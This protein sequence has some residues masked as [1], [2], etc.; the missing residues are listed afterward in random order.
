MPSWS[1]GAACTSASA[2]SKS[3][4][5]RVSASDHSANCSA[6]ELVG[7]AGAD[8]QR[9]AHALEVLGHV[10]EAAEVGQVQG[11]GAHRLDQADRVQPQVHVD[12]RRRRGRDHVLVRR[13]AHAGGVAHVGLTGGGVQVAHVVGGV[14]GRVG[15]LE[16]VLDGLAALQDVDALAI[17]R[18]DLAPQ[19]LHPVAVQAPGAGHAAWTGRP[20][21]ARR[22]R[23]RRP[24]ARGCAG[25]ARRRR[26]RGPGGR[27]SAAAPAAPARA[28]P[29]AFPRR[30]TAPG[31]PPGHSPRRRR[32]RA[33]ARGASSRWSGSSRF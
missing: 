15:H 30:T 26:R 4:A 31:R 29:A 13:D 22:A 16:G 33:R 9:L 10:V 11:R 2:V 1:G 12:V 19:L 5:A 32:S 8:G 23:A 25:P 18:R 20:R 27:G 21:A 3:T 7:L 6:L 17:D 14:A 24:A 28:R